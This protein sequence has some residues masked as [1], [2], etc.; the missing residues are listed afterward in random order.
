MRLMDMSS[1]AA[2][3]EEVQRLMG[4]VTM[5]MDRMR[6]DMWGGEEGMGVEVRQGMV[7]VGG[8]QA[9]QAGMDR[10]RIAMVTS[11]MVMLIMEGMMQVGTVEDVVR[12]PV[13]EVTMEASLGMATTVM[14]H[15]V[16]EVLDVARVELQGC[17]DLEPEQ[18]SILIVG[19]HAPSRRDFESF[20]SVGMKKYVKIKK[21]G[22]SCMF[23]YGVKAVVPTNISFSF[24]YFRVCAS[25]FNL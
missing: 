3:T 21:E 11:G 4:G 15:G 25:Y 24:S 23:A 22:Q 6:E 5:D 20:R 12:I 18:P 19:G 16:L 2:V 8:L 13:M 14:G 9:Q 17:N 10:H 1:L 7:D